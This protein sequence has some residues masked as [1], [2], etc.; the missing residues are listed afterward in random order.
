MTDVGAAALPSA[1][2]AMPTAVAVGVLCA[3]VIIEIVAVPAVLL[4]GGT[5][6]LLAGSL[7][8]TG[9]PAL[10]VALPVVAAVIA[11][12]QL[13]YF[14]GSAVAG[15]WRRR[16]PGRTGGRIAW[17][18]RA[19]AWLTAAMPSLAGGA[20]IRY[21]SFAA[22]VVVMRVPWLAAALSAGTLA[23]RSL[24][25]IG[26]VAGIAGI[27]ASVVVVVGLLAAR[28]RPGMMRALTRRK[29]L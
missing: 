4:P 5:V 10:A 26:H 1:L 6:T 8:G 7:I 16:R 28:H 18:G 29:G 24:A 11:G 13:A 15:W 20:G 19:A 21:R 25:G 9:R 22:R 2:G 27:A 17:R 23:A 12:D 14:S 3:A